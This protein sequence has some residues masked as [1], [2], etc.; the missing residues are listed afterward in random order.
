MPE[1]VEQPLF[2]PEPMLEHIRSEAVRI[3]RS[4]SWC[5]QRAWLLARTTLIALP[6]VTDGVEPAPSPERDE[7]ELQLTARF[8]LADAPKQ[9]QTLFFPQDMIIEIHGEARRLDRSMSWMV[10]AAWCV[11]APSIAQLPDAT[12]NDVAAT[13]TASA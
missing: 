11:A 7:L 1:K 6:T 13:T 3:D 5:A 10:Q 9:K 2:F 8:Q 4:A 12:V